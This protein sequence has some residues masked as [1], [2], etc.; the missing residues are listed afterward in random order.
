MTYNN[1][2][3][4]NQTPAASQPQMQQNFLQIATSYN[5]DHVPLTSGSNVGFHQKVTIANV[6]SAGPGQ[7]APITSLYTKTVSGKPQLFFQ[8]GP[9]ASD[10]EQISGGPDS[11]SGNG[12]IK[13]PTGIILQWGGQTS[14]GNVANVT[15]PIP[16]PNNLFSIVLSPNQSSSKGIAWNNQ[17]VNGFQAHTENA[18]TLFNWMAIG[19]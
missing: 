4:S 8:N 18:I 11:E 5:T 12:Y 9:L 1:T 16:F 15:F 17:S 2:P 14:A 19:N 7:I 6:L 13:F 3:L 10:E